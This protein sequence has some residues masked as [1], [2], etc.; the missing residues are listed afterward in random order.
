MT[1]QHVAQQ[2]AQVRRQLREQDLDAAVGRCEPGDDGALERDGMRDAL[3]DGHAVL[4][5]RAL[6][7]D[8]DG[9][10]P[11]LRCRPPACSNSHPSGAEQRRRCPDRASGRR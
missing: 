5:G 10:A 4:R 2:R 6:G 11:A 8:A 3:G 7:R 9:Q 1:A